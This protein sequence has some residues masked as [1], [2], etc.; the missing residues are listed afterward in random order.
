MRR[1]V[2][3]KGGGIDSLGHHGRESGHV[4]FKSDGDVAIEAVRDALAR[5][6]GGGVVVEWWSSSG[7]VVVKW[8]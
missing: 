6:H 7:G 8:W 3:A 1:H 4:T 5:R 2:N